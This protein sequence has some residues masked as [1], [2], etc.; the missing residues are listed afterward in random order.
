MSQR[1]PM[2]AKAVT[3][4][5]RSKHSRPE[6]PSHRFRAVCGTLDVASAVGRARASSGRAPRVRHPRD[7][8]SVDVPT[9]KQQSG[10]RRLRV[11]SEKLMGSHHWV[12][13]SGE[14]LHDAGQ[15][16]AT[17][18][19]WL[20]KNVV[21]VAMAC[22][23]GDPGAEELPDGFGRAVHGPDLVR[24]EA[25]LRGQM[26]QS[27]GGVPV[28]VVGQL[29]QVPGQRSRQTTGSRRAGALSTAPPSQRAGSGTC[30]STCVHTTA[31][32]ESSS[33]GR[34]SAGAT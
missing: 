21:A 28:V 12:S 24:R 3:A 20:A 15:V 34:S 29:V 9:P 1:A 2:A 22:P 11:C 5:T 6:R 7:P 8:T 31:S 17:R 27:A 32:R 16:P 10:S 26:G 30:S 25:G 23:A 19:A 4:S 33:S 18:A 13:R 14:R